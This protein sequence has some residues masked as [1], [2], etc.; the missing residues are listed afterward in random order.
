MDR[1]LTSLGFKL[2]AAVRTFAWEVVV[3]AR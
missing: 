2:Q 3:Y 1:L